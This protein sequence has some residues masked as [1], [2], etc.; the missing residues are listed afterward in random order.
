MRSYLD[1]AKQALQQNKE[2]FWARETGDTNYE[3]NEFNGNRPVCDGRLPPVNRRSNTGKES[4]RLIDH[5]AEPEAFE[6][7]LDWAMNRTDAA[8]NSHRT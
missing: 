5:L 3:F 8:D 1:I 2:K 4:R 6:R 7:W